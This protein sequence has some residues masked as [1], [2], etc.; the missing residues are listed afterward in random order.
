MLDVLQE[1]HPNLSLTGTDAFMACDTLPSLIDVD[2]T[3][4]GHVE[5]VRCIQ[6]GAGPSGSDV[7]QCKNYLLRSLNSNIP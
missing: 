7:S 6:G 3:G 4:G 2:I 5:V 1:N